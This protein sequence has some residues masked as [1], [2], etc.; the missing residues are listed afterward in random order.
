MEKIAVALSANSVAVREFISGIFRF[1]NT[2]HSLNLLLL[3]DYNAITPGFVASARK[4]GVDGVITGMLKNTPGYRALIASNLP[5]AFIGVPKDTPPPHAGHS[6]VVL[7]DDRAIGR[8]GATYLRSRGQIRSF[9]FLR[10]SDADWA[11]MRQ[12]GFVDEMARSG[13]K[14]SSQCGFGQK[15]TGRTS[16]FQGRRKSAEASRRSCNPSTQ[17]VSKSRLCC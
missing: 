9:A 5:S 12:K 4:N 3:E 6:M 17:P 15:T 7:N 16:P 10:T 11:V 8:M 1:A 14:P 2:R 13:V